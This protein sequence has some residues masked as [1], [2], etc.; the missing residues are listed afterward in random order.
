MLAVGSAPALVEPVRRITTRRAAILL[1]LAG[2]AVGL[3][4]SWIP[5]YWGDEAASV[6]SASRSWPSLGAVLATTDSVHGLYYALLHIWVRAFGTSEFATRLPSAVA[7]GFMVAGTV[8]LVRRFAGPRVA[9]MAGV[10]CIVLPR[11]TWM[12]TEARSYALG[13]AAAVWVT[14]LFIRLVH[15]HSSRRAWLGYSVS[16]AVAMYVFLDLGLLLAVHGAFVTLICRRE[17]RRWALSAVG[18]VVLAWPAIAVGY[19]ERHQV[20]FL[21][22][23]DYATL[24]NVMTKQWFGSPLLALLGW[25]LIVTAITAGV[26]AAV[27]SRN[28]SKGSVPLILLCTF[29]L[30]LPTVILLSVNATVSPMYNVRYLSFCTPA[31]ATLMAVGISEL[32]ILVSRRRRTVLSG[33][34]IGVLAITAVPVFAGQRTPWA[35]DGGSDLRDVAAYLQADA[36]AGDAVVFDQTTKPSRDPRLALDLYPAAFG[37]LHDIALETPYWNRALLWDRV[38][39]NEEAVSHLP[40]RTEVWAVELA[41]AGQ[42]PDDVALLE[43]LGFRMESAQ[44]L[45]RTTVYHLV[46]W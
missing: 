27:R 4:G 26:R 10:V 3:T 39:P 30:I 2:A 41:Q 34:L 37:D 32:S 1:G 35:K 9:I 15:D 7:G 46:R 38:S 12:A 11:T 25:L 16:M 6:M 22:H 33:V 13:T 14:V 40:H 20:A 36:S 18:A 28:L 29:W 44:L 21:A 45:H 23:R 42:T 19:F 17:M 43:R 31:A 5:S 24:A 8:V